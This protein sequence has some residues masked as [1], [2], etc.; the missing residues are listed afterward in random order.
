MTYLKIFKLRKK[1][2]KENESIGFFDDVRKQLENIDFKKR[3]I[4]QSGPKNRG[5]STQKSFLFS[6][7]DY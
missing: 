4:N 2:S 1:S 3:D 7:C 5:Y 6:F